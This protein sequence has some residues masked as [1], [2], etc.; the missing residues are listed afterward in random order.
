M[1]WRNRLGLYGAYFLGI[2]GIGFTLPYLPL[3]LGQE[4]MSDR[5]IG[6]VS[7]LA[8]LAGL[9]Q[10]PLGLWSDRLG[11]RKPFLLA[12]LAILAAAT[13]LLYIAEGVV[14]LTLLVVLFAEN[15]LCRST[16]ESLTGA[17][18]AHLAS[19]SQVGAALGALRFWKPISIVLVALVGGFIAE[20][21]GVRAVLVP[22]A[23]VQA[24]AIVAGLLIREG[25]PTPVHR[26]SPANHTAEP[27]LRRRGF[28]GVLWVFI[29]AMVL[30]HCAN[31]PAGVYLGLCTCLARARG[32]FV[33]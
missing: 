20:A 17:E 7:T 2:S 19:P 10:Y 31:A 14:W 12:A 6:I 3:Y 21:W 24:L 8:A 28:D 1:D 32:V 9:V 33:F 30:F 13:G 25:P 5:A 29:G 16:V 23:I 26:E 4:G 27:A 15:G 18:A 22:L 11:R